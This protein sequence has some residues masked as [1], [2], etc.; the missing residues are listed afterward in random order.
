M[1]LE[2]VLLLASYFPPQHLRINGQDWRVNVVKEVEAGYGFDGQ[3]HC[4]T[5]T[6]EIQAN[7]PKEMREVMVHELLARVE[8]TIAESRL[9]SPATAIRLFTARSKSAYSA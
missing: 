7:E 6:I 5:R 4:E 1:G 8:E 9:S 3:T 2:F